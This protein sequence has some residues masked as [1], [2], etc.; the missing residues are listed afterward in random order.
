MTRQA[1]AFVLTL[2]AATSATGILMGAATEARADPVVVE[3]FTSQGCAACPPADAMLAELAGRDDVLPLALHVDYWDYIG[4]ADT[5]ALPAFT[6]RQKRYAHAAGR[7]MIFTPQI[8]VDGTWDIAGT[9]PMKVADAIERAA[10]VAD[11]VGI[12]LVAA[13]GEIA[14]RIVPERPVP[15][16]GQVILARFRP[17]EQVT[18]ERGEN[19]GQVLDYVNVVSEWRDLGHWDGTGPAEIRAE[20]SGDAPGAVLLQGFRGEAPGPMLAAARLP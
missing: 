20:L 12:E 19:A 9:K 7:S 14:I 13:P 3:L 2:G 11:L 18:I 17:H 5:F 4:W 8:I 15:G 1:A 10:A 6:Q 16:G